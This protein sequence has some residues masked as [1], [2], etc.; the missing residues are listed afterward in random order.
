[1]SLSSMS[2][3]DLPSSTL[4]NRLCS[5]FGAADVVTY[6]SRGSYVRMRGLVGLLF[7]LWITVVGR[8][9]VGSVVGSGSDSVRVDRRGRVVYESYAALVRPADG[10]LTYVSVEMG[11]TPPTLPTRSPLV[12]GD[13]KPSREL[14]TWW[15]LS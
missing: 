13:T 11:M 2:L 7:A 12:L 14:R 6:A 10:G 15:L 3:A 4:Y 5:T 9:R 1:M 8:D